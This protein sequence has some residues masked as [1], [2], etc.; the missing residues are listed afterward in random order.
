MRSTNATVR[1]SGPRYLQQVKP[2]PHATDLVET[3]HA[4]GKS[5][6][7]ASSAEKA[8]VEYYVGLLKLSALLKGTVSKDDVASSKPAGDIFAAALAQIFP[9]AASETLAIGDTPYDVESALR[10][11]VKTIALRSGGYS[12]EVLVGAGAF[13]VYASVKALFDAFDT[14]PLQ[15]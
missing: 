10:S 12:E 1:S 6:V 11:D 2:F 15:A 4:K 9:T 3:L 13:F 7:L 5:V 14:S 8:E